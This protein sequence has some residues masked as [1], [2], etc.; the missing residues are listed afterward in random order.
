MGDG[1]RVWD[2]DSQR[3][4]KEGVANKRLTL[5]LALES[6]RG[7]RAATCSPAERCAL[8]SRALPSLR[9]CLECI[10]LGLGPS[11]RVLSTEFFRQS[12][13]DRVLLTASTSSQGFEHT[14]QF[15]AF[16]PNHPDCFIKA[17]SPGAVPGHH[18]SNPCFGF[19]LGSP[20]LEVHT[21]HAPLG[22]GSTCHRPFFTRE[23]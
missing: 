12:S 7:Y 14:V 6:P 3:G 18:L 20:A 10:T 8:C 11:G 15:A 4:E 23:N 22:R 17:A 1:L 19:Q 21:R 2:S 16:R 13:S 9:M 5:A